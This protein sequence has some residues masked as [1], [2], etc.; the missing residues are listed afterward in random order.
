MHKIVTLLIVE[1]D[2]ID[3]ETIRR[4][5]KKKKI[6]NPTLRARDGVEALEM[7]RGENGH[8]RIDKPYIML[9]DI[10]MPRMNGLELLNEIRA[11][12][13][14]K[15]SVVF[16]LTTSDLKSDRAEAFNNNVAGYILKTNAG[17]DFTKAI[18]LL[19]SYW[20]YVELP[21]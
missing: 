3:A 16:I 14:L 18:E 7:L 4:S 11:D 13:A 2:E 21:T 12:M 1:D 8:S 9:V 17:E 6:N 15:D 20:K 5:M 10:N 19:D